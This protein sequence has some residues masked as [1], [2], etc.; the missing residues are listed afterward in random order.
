MQRRKRKCEVPEKKTKNEIFT[1]RKRRKKETRNNW[2]YEAVFGLFSIYKSSEG[3]FGKKLKKIY[4]KYYEKA[5]KN[6]LINFILETADW[7]SIE[8][9]LGNFT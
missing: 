9:W 5:A 6:I 8:Y 3:L 7:I 4:D 1:I 2:A